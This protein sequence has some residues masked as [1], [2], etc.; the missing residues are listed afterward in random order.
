MTN[1]E[2]AKASI[3]RTTGSTPSCSAKQPFGY[4][5]D[6]CSSGTPEY[7]RFYL[8]FDN[9]ARRGWTRA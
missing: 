2:S 5:G 6:I 8:S 9:G 3:R 7:V 1:E 4:G